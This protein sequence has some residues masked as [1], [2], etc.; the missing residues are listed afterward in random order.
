VVAVESE[1]DANRIRNYLESKGYSV[2]TASDA[3]HAIALAGTHL[4]RAMLVDA[5]M[6]LAGAEAVKRLSRVRGPQLRVIAVA[7]NL[8]L[9]TRA[10]LNESGIDAIL[11]KPIDLH[12]LQ[13]KLT[14]L[15][16]RPAGM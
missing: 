14:Q 10:T 15:L 16:G 3:Y 6:L 4:Y 7:A 12:A 8:S 1:S 9:S 11:A 13:Q 5:D 2:D